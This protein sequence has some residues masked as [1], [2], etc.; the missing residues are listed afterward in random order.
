MGLRDRLQRYEQATN[1]TV[2]LI[3]WI[4]LALVVA[5]MLPLAGRTG[6]PRGP[7]LGWALGAAVLHTAATVLVH[8]GWAP[9]GQKFVLIGLLAA[10]L[11]GIAF[12]VP[13]SNQHIG[14]WFLLPTLAG[15]Y[16]ERWV[17]VVGT[18]LALA[19]WGAVLLFHPPDVPPSITLGRIGLVGGVM[20]ALVGMGIYAIAW[21]SRQLLEALAEAAAQEDVLHRLDAVV[22]GARRTTREVSAAVADLARAGEDVRTEIEVRL[23]PTVLRL[24]QAS[25][26]ARSAAAESHDA[27][28][29]LTRSVSAVSE[30][31]RTQAAHTDRALALSR[32]MS[33]VADAI[34]ALAGEVAAQAEQARRAVDDGRRS[35]ERA[36]E[37][38]AR[39]AQATAEAADAMVQLAGYSAQIGQ[40]V[41]TIEQFAGQTRMLALNAAIEAARAGAAGRGFAVVADE[42]G[43]LA[44]QSSQ[45]AAEIGRLIG[46]VQSGIAAA[47][48]V[49]SGARELAAEGLA[50]S[51]STGESLAE[52]QAAVGLTADRMAAITAQTAHLSDHSH[53]LAEALDQLTA[54]AHENSAA[55]EQMAATAEQLAA[56][57]RVAAETASTSAAV[58]DEVARAADALSDLTAISSAGVERLRRAA[59]DLSAA[60]S[61]N[62]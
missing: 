28:V 9:R 39:L 34:T 11:I 6:L 52:L 56:G 53:Q 60:I 33:E 23:R 18:L 43:K 35:V 8:A 27:L 24:T 14:I 17:S 48:S 4:C 45:A 46:R 44:A 5:T 51:A 26:D 10:V 30:G 1:R 15:L 2:T 61:N 58:A 42:V 12:L 54:I 31:A 37:G 7:F 29:E 21:R 13:G 20:L 49:M 36:A 25:G 50:L 59:H 41:T 57:A 40:V 55:A 3:L 32:S 19:G 62:R 38:T 47:Q 16:V 22:A